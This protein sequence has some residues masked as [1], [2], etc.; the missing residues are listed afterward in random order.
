M[1]ALPRSERINER[2]RIRYSDPVTRGYACHVPKARSG[3]LV[4]ANL[5][6]HVLQ[7]LDVWF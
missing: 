4:P 6:V 1:M 5:M 2:L 7:V 3:F